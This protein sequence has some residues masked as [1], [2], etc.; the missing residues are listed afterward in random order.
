MRLSQ[1]LACLAACVAVATTPAP[2]D[3]FEED[4]QVWAPVVLQLDIE[5]KVLRAWLEV[6]PRFVDDGDRLGF[7]IWRPALGYY[8]TDWLTAWVG[9]AFVERHHPSYVAEHRLWEQLQASGRLLDAPR[10]DG[11]VRLRLEQR[12]QEG[13]DPV[14]H[15]L[16]LL[17]RGSVPLGDPGPPGL[18]A[19]VWNEVFVGFNTTHWGRPPGVE[20]SRTTANAIS[21]LDQNRTFV[22]LGFAAMR[23]LRVEAGY[24][25]QYVHTRG[26]R[27]DIGN[28]VLYV[29][30]MLELP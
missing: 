8:L 5:P 7:V 10:L 29:T 19:V 30:L 6:Q 26:D 11:A 13:E 28:H 3:D 20:R 12:L 4:F 21:G 9:Y 27:D 23:Q 1:T 24:L 22:G 16:R 15:R 14:A 17:V 25:F 2:A 18:Y